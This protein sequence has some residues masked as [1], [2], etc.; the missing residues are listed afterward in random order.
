MARSGDR[1]TG[2]A[3]AASLAAALLALGA[4]A[5]GAEGEAAGPG[6]AAPVAATALSAVDDSQVLW[7][8]TMTR[9]RHQRSAS[10]TS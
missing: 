9:A 8:G 3:F 1:I 10:L 2:A 5:P 7:T 6:G 4:A